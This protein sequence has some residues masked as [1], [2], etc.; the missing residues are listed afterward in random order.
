MKK[1]IKKWIIGTIVSILPVLLVAIIILSGLSAVA[2]FFQNLFTWGQKNNVDIDNCSIEQLIDAV[3]DKHV[4]TSDV[5]KEMMIDRDS[6]VTLLKTVNEYNNRTE[7]RKISVEL[8]YAYPVYDKE[9]G[10]TS[11]G[12]GIKYVDCDVDNNRFIQSYDIDWQ[13]VYIFCIFKA[14]QNYDNWD[15]TKV[16]YD[17]NGALTEAEPITLTKDDVQDVIDTIAPVFVYKY[18]VVNNKKSKYSMGDVYTLPNKYIT[19]TSGERTYY[20]SIPVSVLSRVNGSSFTDV[21]YM[22]SAYE[23]TGTKTYPKKQRF[24]SLAKQYNKNFKLDLYNELLKQLPGGQNLLSKY[25]YLFNDDGTDYMPGN[26]DEYVTE[27]PDDDSSSSTGSKVV[28]FAIQFEGNPYVW[29]GTSLTHG[30]DC[31]GFVQSVFSHYGIHLPR[32]SREQ[33]AA[34]KEIDISDVRPGDLLFYTN[35]SGTINHVALYI[36]NHKVISGRSPE[37]GIGITPY[38]YRHPVKAV[39]FINS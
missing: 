8:N 12:F 16:D 30:A 17:D 1:K 33:A 27:D 15:Y 26:S 32:T 14:L 36:G 35:E 28:D 38:N 29:G 6:L 22:N 3:Q 19:F 37:L 2:S 34:G 11:M 13:T 10:Q 4:F 24:L 20:G 5:L 9:T 39:S 21:Y 23:V 31:S 7:S 25:N 18:D